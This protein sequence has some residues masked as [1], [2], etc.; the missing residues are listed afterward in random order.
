[1]CA[2]YLPAP[3]SLPPAVTRLPHEVVHHGDAPGGGGALRSPADHYKRL[4]SYEYKQIMPKPKVV[5]VEWVDSAFHHG[6]G[7]LDSKQYATAGRC[8]T[9][10]YLL[11]RSKVEIVIA[12]SVGEDEDAAAEAI[13]IPL[14]AVSRVRIIRK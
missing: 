10:G 9:A 11:R 1:M 5:E 7:S 4:M 13:A 12:H 14:C 6:W 8:R 2:N 3:P